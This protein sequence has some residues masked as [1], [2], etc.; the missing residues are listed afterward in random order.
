MR[1]FAMVFTHFASLILLLFLK[2]GSTMYG[3]G[4]G[5]SS[6]DITELDSSAG[7]PSNS[8]N[9]KQIFQVEYFSWDLLNIYETIVK[10]KRYLIFSTIIWFW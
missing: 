2:V 5:S 8:N 10:I 4:G 7:N 6:V 9:P 3:P 1:V